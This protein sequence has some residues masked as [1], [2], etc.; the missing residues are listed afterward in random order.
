[1][2]RGSFFKSPGGTQPHLLMVV[3]VAGGFRF[4]DHRRRKTREERRG[5]A[6]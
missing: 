3:C 6:R 5:E 2:H 1:M 4:F